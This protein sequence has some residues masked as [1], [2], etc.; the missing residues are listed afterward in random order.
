VALALIPPGWPLIHVALNRSRLRDVTLASN[1]HGWPAR[2]A[3]SAAG[4]T[5][6]AMELRSSGEVGA[7]RS[8][9]LL[10]RFRSVGGLGPR[11]QVHHVSG[12]EHPRVP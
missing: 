4:F 6:M 7:R 11:T 9:L 10:L 12:P 1:R 5:R 8:D 2:S 3:R